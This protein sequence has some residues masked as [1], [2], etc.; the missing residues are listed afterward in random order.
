MDFTPPQAVP[1]ARQ[2]PFPAA[3]P[4]APPGTYC[5]CHQWVGGPPDFPPLME[6]RMHWAPRAQ[7][8]AAGTV[9]QW[10]EEWCCNSCDTTVQPGEAMPTQAQNPC[11][12]CGELLVWIYDAPPHLGEW[13]CW[14]C[15]GRAFFDPVAPGANVWQWRPRRPLPPPRLEVP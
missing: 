8:D 13:R 7:H 15:N 3:R 4:P 1:P 10:Q 12:T 9:M 5:L 6:R 11:E 2:G 14:R